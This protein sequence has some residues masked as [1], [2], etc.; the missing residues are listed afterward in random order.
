MYYMHPIMPQGFHIPAFFDLLHSIGTGLVKLPIFC[1]FYFNH[2]SN[3]G[4]RHIQAD[5]IRANLKKCL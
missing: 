4:R 3:L 5:I 1:I 2:T